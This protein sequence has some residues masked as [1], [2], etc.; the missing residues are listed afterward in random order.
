MTKL[1]RPIFRAKALQH[2]MQGREKQVLPRFLAPSVMLFLWCF[3]GF[4]L[5]AGLLS[6]WG[7]VPIYTTGLGEV[8]IQASKSQQATVIV[9]LLSAEEFSKLHVGLPVLVQVGTSGPQWQQTVTAVEPRVMSPFEVRSQFGLDGAATLLATQPSAVV[10]IRSG[11][12]LTESLYAG[13]IVRVQ[14]QVGSQR[15]ISL[16]PGLGELIRE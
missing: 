8:S 4:L 7:R 15:I 16:F 5:L 14:V 3:V 12:H 10:L 2:Y 6:W 1:E 13:S 11:L 9:A